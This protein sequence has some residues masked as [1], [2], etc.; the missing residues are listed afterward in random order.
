M[1]GGRPPDWS[2]DPQVRAWLRRARRELVPKMEESAVIMTLYSGTLDPK[3]AIETGYA[4]L[5]DKP[6]IGAVTAG[7]K[8]PSKLVLICDELVEV[9]METEAGRQSSARRISEAMER[10]GITNKEE[11]K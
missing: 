6:M 2:D 3:L 4:V 9:D 11:P 1:P 5:L 8:A 7:A 10:L